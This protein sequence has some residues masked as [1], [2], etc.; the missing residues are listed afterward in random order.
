MKR[1]L[2]LGGGG[3][4]GVAWEIGLLA[5][6]LDAGIDIRSA[7]LVIGTSAGSVVGSHIAYGKDPRDLI[8]GFADAP[9]RGTG[10]VSAPPRD[11]AAAAEAFGL[12]ASYDEMTPARCAEV[13]R[14]ALAARTISEDEWV[15]GFIHSEPDPWPPMPY[16]AVAV[17][18]ESG[19]MRAFDATQGVDLRRAIAASCAV[20]ALFPPVTIEGHRYMD[21]GVHS[22]TSADLALHITPDAV[23]IIAPLGSNDRGIGALCRR[24]IAHEKAALEAA[25]AHVVVVHMDDAAL[26]AS[27]NG[28]MDASA[29]GPV[30]AAG[31]AHGLRLAP[32]LSSL[33]N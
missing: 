33:W 24:Q 30:A 10:S 15:A 8:D 31:R 16:V 14:F 12:W 25:G 22:G 2:V 1:A 29:R 18:C 21:G 17:D 11:T 5:G 9:G 27:P 26:A 13:G 6:L 20:P 28:L 19:E 7:D 3:P 32:Q 23:L 4:V